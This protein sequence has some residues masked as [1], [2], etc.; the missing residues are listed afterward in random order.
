MT[1][2][3]NLRPQPFDMI[4]SGAKTI[5][6]RLNDEKRKL[7]QIGDKILF[8]NTDNADQQIL[9]S[10]TNLYP[11]PSFEEL[12][13]KLPLEKCGYLPHEL[14]TASPSDMESYFSAEKQR[15]CGVLGIEI[16][17]TVNQPK[18]ILFDLDGTLTDSGIGIIKCAKLTL[19]HYGLPIP[20]D[21][22]MRSFVGP[23]LRL[24]FRKFGVSDD[25]I[26]EA[27]SIYRNRYTVIGMF[28]NFPY[29]GI[30]E[31]L[32]QLKAQGHRL[33]VAT[34]KPEHMAITILEHFG[35]A[36]YFDRICGAASDDTRSK[37]EEVIAYLLEKEGNP[38]DTIMVGDTIYDIDGAKANH[39][40]AIGVA[41]GYGNVAEMKNAGAQ[42]ADTPE[43]L[44][45]LLNTEKAC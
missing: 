15:T 29:P 17:L 18:H 16:A 42:I 40:E 12:Y 38:C 11:F 37:K 23:P 20:D 1:H 36:Q 24:S 9:V 43:E 31:L 8:T 22:T 39:M 2:Q 14:A 34:S 25:K 32:E 3:M 45:S 10:V 27:I 44:L 35:L 13:K 7:I 26:A 41:W 21:Q 30:A 5:E 6:L 4:A 33:F 28:E 19:A